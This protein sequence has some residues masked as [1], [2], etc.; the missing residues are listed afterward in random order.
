MKVLWLTLR[1]TGRFVRSQRR[2][3]LPFLVVAAVEVGFL[4]LVWLAPYRPFSFI[5]APPINY[6]FG[7]RVLQSPANLW[8]LY[9]VMPYIH[10]T[11]SILLGAFM[12]GIAC[13]MVRQTHAG[14][15]L[16]LREAL[17]ARR[18]RYGRVVL[19]WLVTWGAAKWIMGLA[20]SSAPTAGLLLAGGIALAMFLQMLCVYAI[21]AAVFE[22]ATWWNAIL[23]GVR[24]TFRH[25][26]T[27]L[28]VVA[29]PSGLVILFSMW[30]TDGRLVQWML[31][32]TPGIAVI[33]V[34]ARLAVWTVADAIL[35]VA[36]AHLWWFHRAPQHA[37]APAGAVVGT[38]RIL[39]K[40]PLMTPLVAAPSQ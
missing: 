6:F 38:A 40:P 33:F 7:E 26:I 23:R 39:K 15:R 3:W 8:F 34:V 30:A 12:T 25:P 13:E 4:L 2:L 21:P 27:T 14:E 1:E 24:E 10:L 32:T 28:L 35:T 19:I 9:H 11:A 37:L 5:L 20:F 36:I 29:V 16:S 22:G 17:V 18:V 31:Q